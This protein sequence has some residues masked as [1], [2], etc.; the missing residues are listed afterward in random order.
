MLKVELSREEWEDAVAA[1]RKAAS[2]FD[3]LE[4]MDLAGK[5]DGQI[6]SE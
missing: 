1:I 6:P 3:I 4:W 2:E 5:I